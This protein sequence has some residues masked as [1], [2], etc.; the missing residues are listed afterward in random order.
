MKPRSIAAPSLTE[1]QKIVLSL[2]RSQAA[3]AMDVAVHGPN[4]SQGRP[5]ETTSIKASKSVR[6]HHLEGM[7]SA[8]VLPHP[9]LPGQFGVFATA[10]LRREDVAFAEVLPA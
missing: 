10:P 8:R 2:K 9:L 3:R 7:N 5:V 1:R 6:M 4:P